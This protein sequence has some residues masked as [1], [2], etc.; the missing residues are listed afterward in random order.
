MLNASPTTSAH[1]RAAPASGGAAREH[2]RESIFDYLQR[3]LH[4][5][6]VEADPALPFDFQPGFVG[7]LGY[8]L[9]AETGGR[10]A[11]TSLYP[12]AALAFADRAVVIVRRRVLLCAV[13]ESFAERPAKC[14]LATSDRRAAEAPR[15]GCPVARARTHRRAVGRFRCRAIPSGDIPQTHRRVPRPHQGQRNLRGVP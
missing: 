4:S 14:P 13:L 6:A 12:D 5:R 7:Y 11:H 1:R 10:R 3:Q 9:K 2:L 15:A 8:E